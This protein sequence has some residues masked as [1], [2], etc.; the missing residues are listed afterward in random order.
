MTRIYCTKC[1]YPQVTC[2][3]GAVTHLDLTINVVVLQ[4]EKEAGHAKNTIKL[5]CL[6][7]PSI[8]LVSTSSRS[9]VN[10]VLEELSADCT[11]VLF[12]SSHSKSVE[13]I[14]AKENDIKTIIIIDGTWKQA[15]SIW[16]KYPKLHNFTQGHFDSLPRKAYRIRKSKKDYQLSSIEA[17]GYCIS[18]I[19]KV[20]TSSYDRALN[21]MQIYWDKYK[22]DHS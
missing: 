18:L 4:H 8:Q 3:C 13:S 14:A 20:D 11:L 16:Q 15:Y 19:S 7:S 10:E 21:Q 5:A 12:P 9:Q 17:L 22:S 1:Q 6:V 2:V